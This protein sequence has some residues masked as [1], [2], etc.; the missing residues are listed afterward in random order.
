MGYDAFGLP[1]ENYA[2]KNKMSPQKA[3]DDNIAIFQSQ[4]EALGSVLTGLV[5][6]VPVIRLIINGPN[7]LFLQFFKKGLAYQAEIAINW[8]P[9][10]KTGLANEEVINGRH[11]RCDTPVEKKTAQTMVAKDYRLYADR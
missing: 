6:F 2:I 5:A 1:T 10:C 11:E 4:L 3:T 9:F 7:G 8:C